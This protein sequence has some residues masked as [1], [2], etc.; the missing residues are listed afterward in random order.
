MPPTPPDKSGSDGKA[1]GKAAEMS[2]RDFRCF[3][4]KCHQKGHLAKVCPN[5]SMPKGSQWVTTERALEESKDANPDV[6]SE[7][8]YE[9]LWTRVVSA[10][11]QGNSP[12]HSPVVGPTYKVDV[13]IEGVKTRALL[14]HGSQVS[15]VR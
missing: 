15:I 9:E 10:S 11:D 2:S 14:D 4:C 13:T 3:R 12:D 6:T 1:K 7:V 5:T 8:E